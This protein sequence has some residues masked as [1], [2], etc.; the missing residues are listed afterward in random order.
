LKN[1]WLALFCA[2][3]FTASGQTSNYLGPGVLSR[4]SGD[5]GMRSGQQVDLRYYFDVTGVYD[6]GVQPFAVDDKGNL[7]Q[8]NGLYG[9]QA[10]VG[11]Y[12]THRWRQASLGLDYKGNFYHYANDSALDGSTHALQ[13]GY[14]YQQSRRIVYEMRAIAGTSAQGFGAPGFY[15][16]VP[17]SGTSDLVAGPTSTLFDN[18]VYYLEPSMDMTFLQTARTSYTMGGEG[19]FVRREAVGLADLNGYSLHG[20][21]RHR[22]S[23]TRTIGVTYEHTHYDFPPAFGQSDMD[24]AVFTFAESLGRR[25]TISAAGGAVQAQVEGVE[26]VVLNPILAALL[27]VN[28]G[29]R[30]FYRKSYFP[31]ANIVL[32]G[33]FRTS[34]LTFSGNDGIAPGNGVYLTSR[35]QLASVGYSYTGIQKWNFGLT[36]GYS[37]LASIGQG[38]QKYVNFNGGVGVTYSVSH[39]IHIIARADSRY[40][41]IDLVGYNRTGYRATLGLAFSPGNVPLS[42]W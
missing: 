4:G 9:V 40:Q 12:G 31:N 13:L 6:T 30:T 29:Q 10:D 16:G 14:S 42:L 28:F 33:R 15:G 5:I 11:V 1:T 41:Q 26:Q 19:F 35:Q 18:R 2:V 39:A 21:I 7:T 38:I 34:S 23:K 27:G 22:L 24:S 8:I 36:G 3:G 32:T 25:W 20:S 17:A 37:N